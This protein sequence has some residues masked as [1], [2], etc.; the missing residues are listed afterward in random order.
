MMIY[1]DSA[2]L[3]LIVGRFILCQ[4]LNTRA[5]L[6]GARC[7]CT[8][9]FVLSVGRFTEKPNLQFCQFVLLLLT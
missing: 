8:D 7:T 1:I 9:T 4:G 3:Q 6:S 5:A 2:N